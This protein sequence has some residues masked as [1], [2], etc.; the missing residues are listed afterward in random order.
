[1][2]F[3][4]TEDQEMLRE[5]AMA[6]ARDEM[7]LTHLRALRDKGANGKDPA[8]CQKLAE[9]GFFGVIIPDEPGGRRSA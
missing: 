3:V 2:S 5:T 6:F 7:P 1:M 9:L 4:L 8:T